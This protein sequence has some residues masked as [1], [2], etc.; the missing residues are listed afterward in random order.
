MKNILELE[1]ILNVHFKNKNHIKCALTHRSYLNEHPEC[2]QEH[3]ERLEFL[4]DAVLEFVVSE[5]LFSKM[6]KP[7]GEMTN[8]RA[9]IVRAENLADIAE[10][11]GLERFLFLSKGEKKDNGRAK[12]YIL[13]NAFEA[14]LGAIF[15][16]GGIETARKF[17]EEKILSKLPKIIETKEI[18]DPKSRLQEFTQE[19]FS[20]T[21]CYKV[22]QEWGPDHNKEFLVGASL[23]D[24]LVAQGKGFS[25]QEAEE[26]A[27]R[28]AYE[29]LK[30]EVKFKSQKTC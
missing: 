2:I 30:S 11:I 24:R 10:E 15:V 7:E 16:D 5:N 21:P 27:A 8:L 14:I 12:R 26:A 20:T 29:I 23:V 13:A 6:Q 28:K 9:A 1:D 4:G 22:M 25:K 18:K 19:N 17:I 3:N